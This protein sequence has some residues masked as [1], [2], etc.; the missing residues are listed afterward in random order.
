MLVLVLVLVLVL[1]LELALVVL[2]ET[3]TV[4]LVMKR[5]RRR[6][7]LLPVLLEG[8]SGRLRSRESGESVAWLVASG[9]GRLSFSLAL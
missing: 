7:G 8:V 2:G 4:W 5:K 9:K 3:I 6:R 1:L